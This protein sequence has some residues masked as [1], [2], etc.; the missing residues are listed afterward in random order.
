MIA[1]L[2]LLGAILA[3]AS[4]CASTASHRSASSRMDTPRER[5]IAIRS[6]RNPAL[7][8]ATPEMGQVLASRALPSGFAPGD[9]EYGRRDLL[10]PIGANPPRHFGFSAFEVSQ[11]DRYTDSNGRP[12]DAT[13]RTVRTMRYGV[14]P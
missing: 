10:L 8:F 2:V 12:R 6:A 13:R 14:S 5:S 9:W 1:R 11:Y 3:L 7:L 4:G